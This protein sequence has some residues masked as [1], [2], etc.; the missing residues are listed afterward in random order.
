MSIRTKL[1]SFTDKTLLRGVPRTFR[2]GKYTLLAE[3]DHALPRI[4]A[5][6]PT[7]GQNLVHLAQA[8]E[9]KYPNHPII[10]IGANIGDTAAL[11]RSA[12]SQ[13]I[14]CVEGD[15]R[16]FASLLENTEQM[17]KVTSHQVFLGDHDGETDGGV[18][19]HAGTLRLNTDTSSRPLT[20]RTLDRVLQANAPDRDPKLLKIDTDGYDVAILRGAQQLIARTHPVLFFEFDRRFLEQ[21]NEDGL[22]FL[23]SLKHRGYDQILFYDNYGRLIVKT[24][25]ANTELLRDLFLY[26]H[27][28]ESAFPYYDI[29]VFHHS[30]NDLAREIAQTEKT[31]Q[32]EK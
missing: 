5:K 9:K 20:I 29:A 27:G 6:H 8:V 3:R 15:S 23:E 11:I 2:V 7:F 19:R 18:E 10:D 13:P 12:T 4:L 14:I 17:E 16:F 32:K 25:L 22:V 21:N 31:T 26:T 30:D 24:A 28:K 1:I